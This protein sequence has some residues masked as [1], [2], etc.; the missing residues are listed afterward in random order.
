MNQLRP[1]ILLML[2][3]FIGIS[4]KTSETNSQTSG[5]PAWVNNPSSDFSES[6]YLM[7]VGSGS[8]MADARSRA[9]QNLAQIFRSE[10]DGT[11]DLYSDVQETTRNNSE[12]TSSESVRLINNIRI[13]A[14]EDLMNTEVLQSHLA[15]DG[16][17]YVL[18]GM[19][20]AESSR[21]YHQEMEHNLVKIQ[22]HLAQTKQHTSIVRQL[23]EL[24]QAVLL[25][26]VNENF[27]RQLEIIDPGNTRAEQNR[28][29]LIDTEN[30]LKAVKEKAIVSISMNDDTYPTI[31]DAVTQVFE[32]QGFSTGSLNN[33]LL[34][35][36]VNF[37]AME[38]QLNRD[39]AKFARWDLSISITELANSQKYKTFTTEGRDGA[40]SL[41]D[42]IRRAEFTASKE[43]GS[44]FSRFLNNELTAKN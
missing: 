1:N 26:K 21:V 18:A 28:Q 23:M 33:A 42:A 29:T 35:V 14:N 10:I 27:S 25:S 3:F 2:I 4:C 30:E 22:N 37:T 31:K 24:K 9:M 11:Q 5:L 16:N 39:D 32:E 38:A 43:I 17:Y 36:R 40:L 8:T 41:N 19:N 15:S 13:G 44:K 6:K 34:K 20:R 12:F 7:A